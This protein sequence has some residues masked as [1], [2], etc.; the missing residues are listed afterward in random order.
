MSMKQVFEWENS[1]REKHELYTAIE[2]CIFQTIICFF[3]LS[4][5]N[6]SLKTY[7]NFFCD[8]MEKFILLECLIHCI[9]KNSDKDLEDSSKRFQAII[10]IQYFVVFIVDTRQGYWLQLI[11]RMTRAQ[12]IWSLVWQ[13]SAKTQW[14]TIV[15]SALSYD[16]RNHTF[17]PREYIYNMEYQTN[18]NQCS[19]SRSSKLI[20]KLNA[21][22]PMLDS[23][24]NQVRRRMLAH[25]SIEY[26][27]KNINQRKYLDLTFIQWRNILFLTC[28]ESVKRIYYEAC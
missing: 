23:W 6:D 5:N 7:F 13:S 14:R 8:A 19:M 9:I 16:T 12:K 25:I 4:I 3:P 11:D 26:T 1:S 27:E 24:V 20:P 28:I 18:V 15:V 2:Q 21:N 10:I 22:S 17:I